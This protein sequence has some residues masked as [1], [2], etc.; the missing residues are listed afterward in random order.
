[1]LMLSQL[2]TGASPPPPP[3]CYVTFTDTCTNTSRPKTDILCLDRESISEPP[4]LDA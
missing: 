3:E 2:F 4:S 1:M